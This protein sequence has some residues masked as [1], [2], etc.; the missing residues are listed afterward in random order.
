[1]MEKVRIKC[2]VCG[3]ILEADDNPSNYGKNVTCPN[4]KNR[5]K[6]SSFKRLPVAA[7]PVAGDCE[8]EMKSV[9]HDHDSAGS[10]MDPETG[11]LYPLEEGRNLI[12]RMTHNAPSKASIPISTD[13][14]RMSRSHLYIDVIK[15]ADGHFHA[16][17]S[18]A[19]NLNETMING[20]VLGN[21]DQI[22]LKH[23]DHLSL[24]GTEL[25]YLGNRVNDETVIHQP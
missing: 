17:A 10:L 4:C 3:V 6:F 9:S 11:R 20:T 1:M 23:Q 7:S 2:P 16:Y 21:E 18:N 13:N 5:N 24:S 25:I 22:G 8:T 14:R 15:G 12:G 19:S